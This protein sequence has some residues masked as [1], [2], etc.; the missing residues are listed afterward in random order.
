MTLQSRR[1]GQKEPRAEELPW[2][3]RAKNQV[4]D[5]IIDQVIDPAT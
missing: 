2:T 1:S 3:T 5:P 4:T